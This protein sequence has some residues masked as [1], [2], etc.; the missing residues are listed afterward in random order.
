MRTAWDVLAP[1]RQRLN[2][3]EPESLP[4]ALRADFG[5]LINCAAMA[6]PDA[7]EA[8]P[9][10]ARR[11]NA[12]APAVLAEVCRERG[13]RFIQIS[14]D[15]VF[16]G[17]GTEPLT[18]ASPTGPLSVYGE[19]KLAA[20][21]AVLQSNPQSL[22][23]RVSWLFGGGKPA[24]PDSILAAARQ[25]RP[26][27]AIAD[28]WSTPTYVEDLAWWLEEL[29]GA[30]RSLAGLMHLCHGGSCSWQEY[31]QETVDLAHEL[32]MLDQRR[33]VAARCLGGFPLFR[34]ERPRFT[35]LSHGRFV[36][37]TGIRPD[38]WR[39]ALRRYLGTVNARELGAGAM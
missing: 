14:T 8:A 29:C 26:L 7:C 17:D 2:L 20:E 21:S 23:A 3:A 37:E 27:E 39:L 1:D 6:S 32:G 19:T 4:A 11:I 10:E 34:A 31:A 12:E 18:E 28:K 38:S 22:V 25:E 24:F 15:Y 36:A 13:A 16:P 9:D 5:T 30:H 35:P 33:H